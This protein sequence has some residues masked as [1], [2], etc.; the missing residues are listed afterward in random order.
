MTLLT[1]LTFPD[2][3]LAQITIKFIK[4]YQ[5]TF[6]PDHSVSG[7]GDPLKGCKFYPSCSNYGIEALEKYGFVTSVPRIVWRVL[8]C[9][10]WSHGGVDHP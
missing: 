7:V 2:R 3:A 6:S 4:I 10:P 9:H 5:A 8:R 1:V